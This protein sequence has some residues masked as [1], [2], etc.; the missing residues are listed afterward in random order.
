MA[1]RGLFIWVEGADDK[2][3]F[4]RVIQKQLTARYD[5]VRIIQYASQTSDWVEKFLR[6]IKGMGADYIFTAD[7]DSAKS[8]ED[9]LQKIMNAYKGC[10]KSQIQLVIE[11]IESWYLAG[12]SED[13]CQKL[14]I[15]YLTQTNKCTKEQFNTMIPRRFISR[16]D[17]MVEV[18]KYFSMETAVQKN[19]SFNYFVKKYALLEE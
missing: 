4:E 3:F 9:R 14:K 12:L 17:F 5:F 10:E 8:I 6:S 2:R 13:S 7:F 19:N 15:K 1:V 11:E 18:L 16:V